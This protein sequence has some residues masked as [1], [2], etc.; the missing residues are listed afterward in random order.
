MLKVENVGPVKYFTA[1]LPENG[2]I[3]VLSG[4]NGCGK[5]TTLNAIRSLLTGSGT[6]PKMD[7]A[8]TAMLSVF[9]A[10]ATHT[11]KVVRTGFLPVEHRED[12]ESVAKF[13]EPG[14]KTPVSAD[15][16]RIKALASLIGDEP[17]RELFT[18]TF[19]NAAT[20]LT[21]DVWGC[22]N[23][24]SACN[25]AKRQFEEKAREAEKLVSHYQS[26]AKKYED[27]P[28]SR[29]TLYEACQEYVENVDNGKNP[30][31]GIIEAALEV[32]MWDDN[33]EIIEEDLIIATEQAERYRGY[34]KQVEDVLQDA[35]STERVSVR[36]GR[37]YVKHDRGEILF[38][39]L[40]YG[41]KWRVT[42]D[43][44]VDTIGQS[45][46]IVLD[47]EAWEGLDIY[48]RNAINKYVCQCGIV[49][50]TGES[51]KYG[52]YTYNKE[53]ESYVYE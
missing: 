50:I 37:I 46:I 28:T 41:E 7:G 13:V 6:I 27:K 2:G 17:T 12:R 43:M 10:T 19:P 21:S 8:K 47:Q 52:E 15:A 31:I 29:Y 40:S 9:T 34:A 26:E 20:D 49:V 44:L 33:G 48:N 51:S 39:S 36:N 24:L 22:D 45:G 3:L 38:S 53:K 32:E 18:Q 25:M 35:I 11:K 1:D 5:T 23:I 16:Q 30:N 14:L 42:L 4:P